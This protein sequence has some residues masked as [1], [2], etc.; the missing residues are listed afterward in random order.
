MK[1]ERASRDLGQRAELNRGYRATATRD[2]RPAL[3]SRLV[4]LINEREAERLAA[5]L[6]N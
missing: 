2:A 1:D 5:H 4:H 6:T 3:V